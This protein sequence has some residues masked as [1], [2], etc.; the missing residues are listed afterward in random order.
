[1]TWIVLLA[2]A[3]LCAFV[4]SALVQDRRRRQRQAEEARNQAEAESALTMLVQ[5][6]EEMERKGTGLVKELHPLDRT[7]RGAAL[8]EARGLIQISWDRGKM[9]V[10]LPKKKRPQGA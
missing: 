1:M 10:S 9:L 2:F 6:L 5:A 7:A 3:L 8:G 4:L